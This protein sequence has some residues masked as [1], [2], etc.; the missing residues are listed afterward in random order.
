MNKSHNPR[1]RSINESTRKNLAKLGEFR[2]T[3]VPKYLFLLNAEELTFLV[4]RVDGMNEA[5]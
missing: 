2:I 1:K 5:R 4:I 3:I